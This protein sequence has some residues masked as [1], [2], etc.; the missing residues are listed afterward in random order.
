MNR[1]RGGGR[2]PDKNHIQ[3]FNCHKYG[4]YSSDY[5][6]KQKNQESGAKL[7]KYEEEE[8]EE[9]EEMILMVTTRDEEK[10]KD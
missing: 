6:K 7:A 3:C 9:E 1:G 10:F 4:H 8:E 5:P 2:K